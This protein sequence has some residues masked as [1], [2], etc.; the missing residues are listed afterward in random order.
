MN[1]K[2]DTGV[3]Q[4]FLVNKTGILVFADI[5]QMIAIYPYNLPNKR[6]KKQT[7]ETIDYHDLVEENNCN[8]KK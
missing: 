2:I 1:S 5:L 3:F 4:T 8:N 6:G 7:N